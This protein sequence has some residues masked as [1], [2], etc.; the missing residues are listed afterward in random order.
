MKVLIIS[1]NPMTDYNNMGKTLLAL[2]HNF[3]N[4]ELCQLYIYPTVPNILKCSS[5]FRI[6]D[7][8]VLSSILSSKKKGREINVDEISSE[9]QLY[10]NTVD[11]K[12]FR[13]K[14][15]H[16]ELKLIARE[17]IWKCGKWN[18]NAL[19]K[20]MLEQKPDI[21]FAAP[22]LS[23][24]FYDLILKI[25]RQYH[26]PV[27]SYICDDFFFS[28]QKKYK[29]FLKKYYYKSLQQKITLLIQSSKNVICICDSLSEEY[30]NSFKCRVKTVFS[31]A[32]VPVITQPLQMEKN[33]LRYFGN[34]QLNRHCSLAEIGQALA[35]INEQYKTDYVLEIYSGDSCPD[36]L[37]KISCI[38]SCGYVNSQKLYELMYSSAMLIHVESFDSCDIERVRYSV[39]TKIA[40]SLASGVCLFAYGPEEVA[41]IQHLKKNRCAVV[42]NERKKLDEVLYYYLSMQGEREK[43]VANALTTA[44]NYHSREK[45]SEYVREALSEVLYESTSN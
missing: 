33:I 38:R 24:F 1:H 8:D 7:R 29:G 19:K 21:I 32:N 18:S 41:S 44:Q 30:S 14:M 15:Q 45:Q 36:E 23:S 35:N 6:T 20:W 31:G 9:N 11:Q 3:E 12:M 10:E 26:L 17:I 2:F 25:S 16:K 13:N 37:K 43:I 4:S 42:V 34:L 40:D 28:T 27:V 39:S 5:Y 22:G